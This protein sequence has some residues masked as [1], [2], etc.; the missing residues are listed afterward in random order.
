MVFK[1]KIIK[2]LQIYLKQEHLEGKPI[3]SVVMVLNL[4]HAVIWLD[5][6]NVFSNMLVE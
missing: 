2:Y 1:K 4:F 6:W 3:I 5:M